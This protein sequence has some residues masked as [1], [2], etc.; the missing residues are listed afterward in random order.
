MNAKPLSYSQLQVESPPLWQTLS[1]SS[2]E[3]HAPC[4]VANSNHVPLGHWYGAA[5]VKRADAPR[6][7][8]LAC[9]RGIDTEAINNITPRSF[10]SAERKREK[11]GSMKHTNDLSTMV[12]GM[13]SEVVTGVIT[14]VTSARRLYYRNLLLVAVVV[15][16]VTLAIAVMFRN[17]LPGI[18]VTP[19]RGDISA[20]A[21]ARYRRPEPTP[22]ANDDAEEL[23]R[24]T[25]PNPL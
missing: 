6:A 22:R 3:W 12:A 4:L 1:A 17:H 5:R 20:P 9:A 10:A 23:R 25:R 16:G 2:D 18:S 21:P 8:P 15:A 11:G 14:G 13:V 7:K 24:L 19:A